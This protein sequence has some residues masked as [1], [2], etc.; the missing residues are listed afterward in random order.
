MPFTKEQQ[1]IIDGVRNTPSNSPIISESEAA[2]KG[3][4]MP[5]MYKKVLAAGQGLTQNFLDELVGNQAVEDA[6]NTS[7][8]LALNNKQGDTRTPQD[9]ISQ[10]NAAR[11]TIRGATTQY[12]QDKPFTSLGMNLVGA[13]P[14]M[15][16][17]GGKET[18]AKALAKILAIVRP[19]AAYT[20]VSSVGKTE[21]TNLPEIAKDAA[22]E[23]AESIALGGGLK[24][25]TDVL[26]AAGRRIGAAAEPY[27]KKLQ[28]YIKK[29]QPL[30]SSANLAMQRLATLLARDE[31][32]SKFG[33]GDLNRGIRQS[34]SRLGSIGKEAPLALTG[35]NTMRE[36]DLL[37]N[38]PGSAEEAAAIAAR[39]IQAGRGDALVTGAAT[40]L[41]NK[42][43]DFNATLKQITDNQKKLSKPFYDQL[44]DISFVADDKL[45]NLINRSAK[46]HGGAE[47]LAL[48]SG[49][50]PLDLAKITAGKTVSFKTLNTLKKSLWD[51]EQGAKG[52]FGK[53]T[54]RSKAYSA[55]RRQLTDK[56]DELS[57]VD[58]ETGKSIYKLA[59]STFESGAQTEAALLKGQNSL[60]TDL[61]DLPSIMEDLSP[62]ELSAFRTG[63]GQAIKQL[64]GSQPGQTTLLKV[65][66]SPAL[67]EKLRLI[68]GSDY[69]K[70]K[71]TIL[72]QR[73]LKQIERV[74][75]GSQTFKRLKQDEDQGNL[76]DVAEA[77]VSVKSGNP[78]GIISSVLNKIKKVE[79]PEEAR[80]KL[81]AMLL[82]KGSKAQD[83]LKQLDI[84][85][86]QQLLKQGRSGRRIGATSAVT[87]QN[88]Q[89]Q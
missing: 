50:N 2:T 35:K 71:K 79:M 25:G 47:E 87:T 26:S 51:I 27:I 14:T 11:D 36:L 60:K 18:S 21:K 7:Q 34:S 84:Y 23:S 56:L 20:T 57:P 33:T 78:Q 63:V 6:V 59:R 16:I 46:A 89:E 55:L 73:E 42:N 75:G 58:K 12:E 81:T 48:V 65:T 8:M 1:A 39:K 64:T 9:L 80:N 83:V 30:G 52:E 10:R 53:A 86:K 66:E 54:E 29:L 44:E 5:E 85:N 74:G 19:A 24:V 77:A 43:V 38:L 37:I 49:I 40:A 72:Q 32:A 69:S 4:S 70:F 76:M 15:I 68:F 28:P 88:I 45:I 17:G 62:S 82:A 3:R 13:V 31:A 61:L 22:I 41:K 67:K